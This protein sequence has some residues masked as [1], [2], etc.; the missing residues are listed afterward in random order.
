MKRIFV[1]EIILIMLFLTG[2]NYNE[3]GTCIVFNEYNQLDNKMEQLYYLSQFEFKNKR[4]QVMTGAE[5][6]QLNIIETDENRDYKL[7]I[8][9]SDNK[10]LSSMMTEKQYYIDALH[11]CTD[12]D[13][14]VYILYSKWDSG[15]HGIYFPEFRS[16]HI[17][18]MDMENFK[19]KNQ[20]DFGAEKMV[21]T[22]YDSY[23][24]FVEDGRV[25]RSKIKKLSEKECMA[26]LGYR[27]F[28]N[29]KLLRTFYFIIKS[30]GIE[31]SVFVPDK[32][33]DN[34][35]SECII[36]DIKYTDEPIESE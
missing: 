13:G 17:L 23:V 3:R 24:Y 18:E 6:D 5:A 26:D 29:P 4:Y 7:V 22:V 20:Y 27:G 34:N 33:E 10:V 15:W 12:I 16:S 19:V 11:V 32:K 31:I 9:D 28:P 25:Y 8:V 30:D 36:A 2:C 21:L 35:V 14:R 1:L